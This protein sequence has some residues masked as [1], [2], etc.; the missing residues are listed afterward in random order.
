MAS[1]V[2][3]RASWR[4]QPR[5][6]NAIVQRHVNAPATRS[7]EI[8]RQFAC[9]RRHAVETEQ[10]RGRKAVEMTKRPPHTPRYRRRERTTWHDLFP[11]ALNLAWSAPFGYRL[12]IRVQRCGWPG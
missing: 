2:T 5:A 12:D 3:F 9:R 4:P 7:R 11:Y 10:R 8:R 1:C 6:L